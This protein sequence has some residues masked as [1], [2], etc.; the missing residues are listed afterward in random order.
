MKELKRMNI[1][2]VNERRIYHTTDLMMCQYTKHSQALYKKLNM[3]QR[4]K[5]RQDNRED[6]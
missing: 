1:F 4:Y 6:T 2:L 3:V 5:S